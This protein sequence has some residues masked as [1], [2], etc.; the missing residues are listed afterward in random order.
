MDVDC[1][2]IEVLFLEIITLG[3][4]DLITLGP[5]DD[6]AFGGLMGAMVELLHIQHGQPLL[7]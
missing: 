7:V 4:G 2:T 6:M 5:G 3:P 1:V